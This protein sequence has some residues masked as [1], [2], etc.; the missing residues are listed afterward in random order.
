MDI[1][2]VK[3]PQDHVH[4]KERADDEKRKRLEKLL[5]NQPLPLKLSFDRG[6]QSFGGSF[7]NKIS[8]APQSHARFDVEAESDA[9][10]LVR[11]IDRL[12]ADFGLR[13]REGSNRN[14]FRIVIGLDVKLAQILRLVP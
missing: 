14:Q 4:D 10:K 7:L 5:E 2:L 12:E 9:G 13:F 3:N 11:V 8:Y 1:A 6:R